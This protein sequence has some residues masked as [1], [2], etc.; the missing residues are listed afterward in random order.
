M[1]GNHSAGM[2]QYPACCGIVIDRI[3]SLESE[4]FFV[5]FRSY[6]RNYKSS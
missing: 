3:E 6:P 2:N 1:V 4:T 5:S